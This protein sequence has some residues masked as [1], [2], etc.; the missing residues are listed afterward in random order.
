MRVLWTLAIVIVVVLALGGIGYWYLHAAS[1][2]G[3]NL[4]TEPVV[5]DELLA[6]ISATGT[7]EPEDVVDV[8]A[9]VVGQILR[10]GPD[11]T[12]MGPGLMA[13]SVG[14]L[15]LPLGPGP[16]AAAAALKATK[17]IPIDYGS[18]VLPGSVLASIDDR[19]YKAH[20]SESEAQLESNKAKF[21]SAIANVTCQEANLESAKAKYTQAQRDWARARRL[22][23]GN[24]LTQQEYDGYLAT[25]ETTKAGVNVMEATVAQAKTAVNDA[26][27]AVDLA[28]ATLDENKLNLSYCTIASDIT[29]V[30]IDRR[31]T[32]GQTVV[33]SLNSPSLFLL[34]KDL[35]RIMVW[36]S[37]NEAD[38]SNVHKG[39][40]VKFTVDAHP[41]EVFI[42]IVNR[43][44]LN[45]TMTQNVV[46]Y[47]VEVAVDNSDGRLLP[48]QTATMQFEVSRREDAL[49]VP[50]GALRWK[51][52]VQQVA[53]EEREAYAKSQRRQGASGE[54]QATPVERRV[55]QNQAVVWVEE[56][57]FVR[58]VKVTIGLTD[59]NKTEILKGDL[60][61]GDR[62][63]TGE[64]SRI[65]VE[66]TSNPFAPA[67]PFGGG[68]R[69]QQ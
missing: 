66:T 9:Q 16:F 44:R 4:R 3:S 55:K 6:T 7:V 12:K 20:V 22:G 50:N 47:T 39:Q 17:I 52:Q 42:G 46:T 32:I 37:V 43:I 59:G 30:I 26:K 60:N 69:R 2:H 51:P 34:A 25:Y 54:Q 27:A 36:A 67:S 10:F 24:A 33:S 11:L 35:T 61:E 40:Q 62:L 29:G 38:I 41:N 57:N 28:Q 53:P 64:A 15:A 56:G 23:V 8:G 18:V 14:H 49:L 13:Q 1:N 19:I 58:P 21:A 5:R 31:V 63:V 45:A 65:S 48:Y 68:G